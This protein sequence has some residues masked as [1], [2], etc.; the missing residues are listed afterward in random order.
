MGA[1]EFILALGL[2]PQGLRIWGLGRRQ[3]PG[4][5]CKSGEST[6]GCA[7]VKEGRGAE[8]VRGR[9]ARKAVQVPGAEIQWEEDGGAGGRSTWLAFCCPRRL[10]RG[11]E[12]GHHGAS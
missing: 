3:K 2:N 6:M 7:G 1:G 9:Q 12:T 8:G 10:P 11:R 4:V 5:G